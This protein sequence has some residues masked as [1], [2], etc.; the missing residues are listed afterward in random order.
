MHHVFTL[1]RKLTGSTKTLGPTVG[2]TAVATS[3]VTT[4]AYGKAPT[5]ATTR[6]VPVHSRATGI[7]IV[8]AG[9]AASHTSSRLHTTTE[10]T[11]ERKKKK[12]KK[13]EKMHI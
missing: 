8:E 6:H 1:A 13:N 3:M 7:V 10:M 5:T 4:S 12:K 9:T 11:A 2:T